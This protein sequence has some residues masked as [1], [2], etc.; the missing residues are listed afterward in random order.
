M[1]PENI[2]EKRRL[3]NCVID[4]QGSLW[5]KTEQRLIDECSHIIALR[6]AGSVNGISISDAEKILI[7]HL[8]PTIRS[9]L[10]DGKVAFIFDGDNDDRSYPD[11]GY[12]IGRIRDEFDGENCEF[13]AVQ[14]YD[15]W[16]S[17][18]KAIHNASGKEYKTYVIDAKNPPENIGGIPYSGQQGTEH[19]ALSQS[20]IL[21]NS[22]KYTQWYVGAVGPIAGQQIKDVELK[23]NNKIE[24][25]VFK[26]PVS[27]EQSFSLQNKIDKT[28]EDLLNTLDK[29]ELE[30]KL[31]RLQT[32]KERREANPYG[33]F[34]DKDGNDNGSFNNLAKVRVNVVQV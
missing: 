30:T 12:I 15:W 14:K 8:F 23:T 16:S 9:M 5:K 1:M 29:E 32:S 7:E 6:G 17:D 31:K 33:M 2:L 22:G 11:I 3:E 19:N 28:R 10:N 4:P 13:F 24:V 20:Q 21:I 18:G 34:F 27:I 26:A 25:T